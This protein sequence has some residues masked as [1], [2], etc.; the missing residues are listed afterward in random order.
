MKQLE[1]YLYKSL[2][3]ELSPEAREVL[4]KLIE[5]ADKDNFKDIV[6]Q[7]S[8]GVMQIRSN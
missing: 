4:E 5:S 6:G 7:V 3:D 2:V 1:D 8:R